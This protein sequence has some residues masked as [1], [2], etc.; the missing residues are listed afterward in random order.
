MD[1]FDDIRTTLL[2]QRRELIAKIG[3]EEA[4]LH[5]F[6]EHVDSELVEEGQEGA[7]ALVLERLD[8]HDRAHVLAIDRALDRIRRGDYGRC[9][10][11]GNSIGTARL[12][13]VPTTDHCRRC[14][15]MAEPSAA[16][17]TR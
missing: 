1:R 6:D 10:A 16:S 12:R 13:A 15:A 2:A 9:L 11:C 5:W 7:L 8:E 17:G 14:A 4:D 3:R